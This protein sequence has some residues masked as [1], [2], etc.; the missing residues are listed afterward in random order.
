MQKTVEMNFS[1]GQRKFSFQAKFILRNYRNI[2][3]LVQKRQ[4]QF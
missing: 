3:N 4:D 1:D 2:K